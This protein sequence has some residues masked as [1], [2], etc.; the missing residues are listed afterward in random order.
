MRYDKY[1]ARG[2]PIATGNVEGA[3]KNLVK[4]RMERSGMRWTQDGAESLLRL[5]AT[6]LSDDFEDYW[7]FHIAQEQ[8][9][10]H[11]HGPWRPR[12]PTA[13]N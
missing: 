11:P 2:L 13:E 4:D 12:P 6:Y 10:L 3:A 8:A 1:L 9:R 5:R 7:A